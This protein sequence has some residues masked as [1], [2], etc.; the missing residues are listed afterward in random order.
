MQFED[1]VYAFVVQND[2]EGKDWWRGV[3][4]N[5]EWPDEDGVVKAN[6]S[7]AWTVGLSRDIASLIDSSA[8]DEFA[9]CFR[10][11]VSAHGGRID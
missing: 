6:G 3:Y 7:G 5:S 9:N 8:V 10:Q 4:Q 1:L 11:V 2:L